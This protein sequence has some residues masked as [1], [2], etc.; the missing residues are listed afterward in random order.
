MRHWSWLRVRHHRR[1]LRVRHHGWWLA[2]KVGLR[3][4]RW[5]DEQALWEVCRERRDEEPLDGMT[6]VG[7][8]YSRHHHIIMI[9]NLNLRLTLVWVV[10]LVVRYVVG[11]TV[12]VI[13]V[14][15]G[16]HI[17]DHGVGSRRWWFCADVQHDEPNHRVQLRYVSAS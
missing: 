4:R 16:R 5:R 13:A 6:N 15:G 1:W 3:I 10:R 17:V 14:L 7:W 9:H 12:M 2:V 8:L 11:V